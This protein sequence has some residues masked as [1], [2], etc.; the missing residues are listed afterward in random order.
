M[1]I[2]SHLLVFVLFSLTLLLG[3]CKKEEAEPQT[4]NLVISFKFNQSLSQAY[5][6]LYTEQGWASNR[7]VSPLRE[8]QLGVAAP[9]TTTTAKV[10]L[11]DLNA[12][13]YVFVLGSNQWSVQVTA[14]KTNNV[15][16]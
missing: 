4:G 6:R 16:K 13:N 11:N 10:E 2:P 5:Y 7:P 9:N 3:A 1:R 14:G 15:S 8:G 12:G